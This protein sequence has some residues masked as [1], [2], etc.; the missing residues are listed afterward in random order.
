MRPQ[1]FSHAHF[2]GAIYG[3][4]CRQVHKIDASNDQH[5][6]RNPGENVN[7]ANVV[8]RFHL[9]VQV[10]MQMNVFDGLQKKMYVGAGRWEIFLFDVFELGF[11][12]LSVGSWRKFDI[13]PETIHVPALHGVCKPGW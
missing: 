12:C 11:E 9:I 8:V 4:R 7:V 3:S 10:G 2:P 13:G 6:N 5:Q 1:D